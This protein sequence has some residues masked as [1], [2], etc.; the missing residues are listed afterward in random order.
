MAVIK[1]LNKETGEYQE[2]PVAKGESAYEVAVKHG[3]T[4]SEEEW[5]ASLKVGI[6]DDDVSI[7]STWSS[8]KIEASEKV[9]NGNFTKVEN[10]SEM[11]DTS[12]VYV[13]TTDGKWYYY[14]GTQW[15]AGGV[16]Q[17]TEIG[18][19]EISINKL[20]ETL[21]K[22]QNLIVPYIDR[23]NFTLGKYID[24]N[25]PEDIDS[26]SYGQLAVTD[27]VE[28]DPIFKTI[29]INFAHINIGRVSAN[30]YD[31]NRNYISN[32][33]YISHLT[34][35][36][37]VYAPIPSNAK[38]IRATVWRENI[39]NADLLYYVNPLSNIYQEINDTN[40]DLSNLE[41]R[42]EDYV[43]ENQVK[44]IKDLRN[45]VDKTFET[46]DSNFQITDGAVLDTTNKVVN[47]TSYGKIIYNKWV[48]A[49]ICKNSIEFTLNAHSK[50][51][52]SIGKMMATLQ[53]DINKLS[54]NNDYASTSTIPADTQAITIPELT[55]GHRYCLELVKV[56]MTYYANLIDL[57]T[58]EKW[59]CTIQRLQN[60]GFGRSQMN[61]FSGDISVYNYKYFL[62][63]YNDEA[64]IIFLGD[65]TTEGV[66]VQDLTKRWCYQ[67]KTNYF[68]TRKCI[69][70]GVGGNRVYQALERMQ[71]LINTGGYSN[72]KYC[73]IY[74]G[75]NGSISDYEEK[76]PEIITLCKNNNIKPIVAIPQRYSNAVQD[77]ETKRDFA[78]AQK[79][80]LIRFDLTSLTNLHPTDAQQPILEEYAIKSL[81]YLM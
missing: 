31:E 77:L 19:E 9:L 34:S 57:N 11:T 51:G 43:D 28:I 33:N 81:D 37:K 56:A 1:I 26:T 40:E 63:Y 17:A 32:Y 59:T 69:I 79:W 60:A 68:K 21:Q 14:N 61:F 55:L 7:D 66:D 39:N 30:F 62:P 71:R 35:D 46:T 36:L 23:A 80:D 52:L 6:K 74:L 25:N 64:E 2:L 58:L 45:V 16:Y 24:F 54:L 13:L 42:F 78:I 29:V 41:T 4:G 67:L 12:K 47:F 76:M 48:E 38:Y 70:N 3:Y 75:L 49:D 72:L 20:D 5:L 53:S 44:Y 50:L 65:S 22:A 15:V 27:Y 73:I 18:D 10:V 8:K